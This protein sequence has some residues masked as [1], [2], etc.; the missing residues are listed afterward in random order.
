MKSLLVLLL[1]ISST[2][3]NASEFRFSAYS[4]HFQRIVKDN[5]WFPPMVGY[6]NYSN[7]L[8]WNQ[9]THITKSTSKT[10]TAEIGICG[11]I[12]STIPE[13]VR[14]T[15]HYVSGKDLEM[16]GEG[17]M[18]SGK[19]VAFE[20]VSKE[21]TSFDDY[22]MA[23][24]TLTTE[25]GDVEY[26]TVVGVRETHEDFPHEQCMKAFEEVTGTKFSTSLKNALTKN[27]FNELGILRTTY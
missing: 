7:V 14:L 5:I 10:E 25:Y 26:V 4:C 6:G 16:T 13:F 8:G 1:V 22:L 17:C 18:Y 3:A 12:H 15:L 21:V 23:R 27:V 19:D 2:F 9:T 24:K 20:S 11:S